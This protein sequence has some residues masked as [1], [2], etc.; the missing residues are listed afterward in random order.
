M[1]RTILLVGR[2]P[3]LLLSPAMDAVPPPRLDVNALHA[4]LC[5]R[6]AELHPLVVADVTRVFLEVSSL[7]CE[8]MLWSLE[9]AFD[10]DDGCIARLEARFAKHGEPSRSGEAHDGYEVHVLLPRIIPANA[11][12][13]DVRAR[14]HGPA[15]APASGSLAARFVRALAALGAYRTIERLEGRSVEVYLL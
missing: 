11:P 9:F 6:I 3:G 14:T 4:R 5:E 10:D 12:A 8:Q 7:A 15:D 13:E 1:L 2:T